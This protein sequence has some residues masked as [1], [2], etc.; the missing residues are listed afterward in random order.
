[1]NVGTPPQTEKRPDTAPNL[2]IK[3]DVHAHTR[4]SHGQAS[5][6]AMF[7]AAQGKGLE[8]FGF[9]EHSPRPDGYTYPSDYQDKLNREFDQ[10][11]K[12]V[13]EL[14]KRGAEEG[15]NVLLGL[16]ADFIPGQEAFA[17]KLCS[18]HPFDYVIGGL[19]FQG[20]WGFDFTA[21]D[22]AVLDQEQR[23]A[24]YAR[25][26]KDL[27]A[28][29]A[30]GLF[31]IAAHPDLIKMFTLDSFNAWLATQEALPAIRRAFA[32]MKKQGMLMEISSAGL[33]KP[34]KE[35]YPGP[36]IM[37]LA[38]EM[39]LPISF[40]SDA[41]CVNTPAYAFDQL[42]RYAASFGYSSSFVVKQGVKQELPFT[43]P[44]SLA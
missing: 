10:Y 31:H 12:E 22:W 37:A 9:S 15:I 8:I 7:L 14:S 2:P 44:A 5:A 4:H 26:Y 38:R 21:D 41:H 29:C 23:F 3:A 34:C 20:T 33:R 25:Y 18:S 36:K 1:M 39:E 16:E 6:E 24:A 13:R 40:G 32:V 11:V 17:Q 28:M 35:I 27:A 42:A 43:A 30:T 19:H